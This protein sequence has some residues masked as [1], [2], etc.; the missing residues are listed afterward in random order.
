MVVMKQQRVFASHLSELWLAA[1]RSAVGAL[2]ALPYLWL[3]SALGERLLW[4]VPGLGGA[5]G[6]AVLVRRGAP[7]AHGALLCGLALLVGLRAGRAAPGEPLLAVAYISTLSALLGLGLLFCAPRSWARLAGIG[8][9]LALA[10]SIAEL[11]ARLLLGSGE[12][13]AAALPSPAQ[14]APTPE[15]AL[16]L[17]I[18]PSP[19][20][21][22]SLDQRADPAPSPTPEAPRL[23]A[24]VGYVDYL[25]DGGEAP[26]ATHTGYGPRV[27]S[28]ARAYML[29]ADGRYIY[30][31]HVEYNSKGM[32]GPEV[33]YEKEADVYRILIIGDS[34]VE[35]VQ[36]A[37]TE[38]FQAIL[39]AELAQRSARGKR[40]EVLA[41]G[42]MGWGTLQEY[43]YYRV[44]GRKFQPD[45][46][47]L[48]FYINDVADNNPRFFY[49]G[50][51][52]T[53]YDFIFEGDDVRIVD[54]NRQA[55]PPRAARR[56]YNAL[57]P[58]LQ[59][60][61]LARLFVHLF[62]PPPRIRTP[63]GILDRVHPQF[64]IYVSDPPVEGYAEAWARTEWALERLAKAVQADGAQF[65]VVSIFIGAEMIANVANW[66]PELVQGWS[67][68][69]DLP[70]RRLAALLRRLNAAF[71]PTRA[72]YE[73]RARAAQTEVHALVFIPEDG[74]FSAQ[75]HRL[76]AE[77]L[78]DWLLSQGLI[79]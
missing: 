5:L 4:T 40:I 37:Y 17:T 6:L 34:F 55:L 12:R 52:N 1:A 72:F 78:R 3:N 27:N 31:T 22:Q 47:L 11:S 45:L 26:W 32:R 33:A 8:F 19:T 77:L 30:D 44:E 73:A 60:A 70:D 38:T 46:V 71:I 23:A 16:S 36:V 42:R 25:L 66:Y 67:W 63:N 59:S 24:G 58:A 65:G 13:S 56:L 50:I 35:A 79:E 10:L 62:D 49:P 69:A 43:L 76:T 20:A 28:I 9:G 15:A 29:D 64:Y 7:W 75:G 61:A 41:M 21:A 48:M 2:V 68:D 53:N 51:N 18:S 74:H 39:Q 14:I 54:T 57:P